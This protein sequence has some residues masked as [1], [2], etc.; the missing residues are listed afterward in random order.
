MKT[1]NAARIGGGTS[2][3]RHRGGFVG[4]GRRKRDESRAGA[5]VPGSRGGCGARG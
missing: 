5:R 1:A 4:T 2:E 3:R